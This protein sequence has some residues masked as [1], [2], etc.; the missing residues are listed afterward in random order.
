M[1]NLESILPDCLNEILLRLDQP[2]LVLLSCASVSLRRTFIQL[3]PHLAPLPTA[4]EADPAFDPYRFTPAFI[5]QCLKFSYMNIVS[6]LQ[7]TGFLS[8]S[9]LDYLLC[10]RDT[11][12]KH[13]DVE[14][15]PD[16]AVHLATAALSAKDPEP[17][18]FLTKN[19]IHP[20]IFSGAVFYYKGL[21][22][23]P[24]LLDLLPTPG[25]QRERGELPRDISGI[26]ARTVIRLGQVG[27]FDLIFSGT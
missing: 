5:A 15:T 10:V 4:V 23:E 19:G 7:S 3:R 11:R 17:I 8:K 27:Q 18:R 22:S 6:W 24:V 16:F 26:D 14:A 13:I 12:F 20:G 21:L 1:A 2:S 25:Y 9:L